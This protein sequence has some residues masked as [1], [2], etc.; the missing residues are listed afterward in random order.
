MMFL[1]GQEK[2][3]YNPTFGSSIEHHMATLLNS[4]SW[5]VFFMLVGHTARLHPEQWFLFSRNSSEVTPNLF[6]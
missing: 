6:I 1:C 4:E 5:N 3:N 2:R